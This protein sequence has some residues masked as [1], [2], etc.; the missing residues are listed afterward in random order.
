MQRLYTRYVNGTLNA[1]L[2]SLHTSHSTGG[3]LFWFSSIKTR[4][5]HPS[6]V[7][8]LLTLLVWWGARASTKYSARLLIGWM[9]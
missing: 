4:V 1:A 6:M 2:L 3:N 9:I 8:M 5:C 7:T